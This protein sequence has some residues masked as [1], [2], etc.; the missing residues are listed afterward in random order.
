HV[1]PVGACSNPDLNHGLRPFG[2]LRAGCGLYFF[3][4]LRL[5]LYK[6]VYPNSP[7]TSAATRNIA[8]TALA[9]AG[10][11]PSCPNL[12]F[13]RQ[14]GS[15]RLLVG[16][17]VA[18]HRDGMCFRRGLIA[19]IKNLVARAQIFLGVP[20]TVQAPLHLQRFLLV[21]EWHLID[22]TVA[23]VASHTL[24]DVNAVIEKYE[25]GKLVDAGPLQGFAAAK[26]GA[27]RLQ[28]LGVGPDLR[29]TVHAGLGGRNAGKT[30]SLDRG[31]AIAAVDAKAR[32]MVLMT[33]WYR[34]RFS[35]TG[36][37]DV[38]RALDLHCNPGQCS[39]HK[40]RAVNCDARQGICTALKNLRHSS[41]V[42]VTFQEA[43]NGALW[44]FHGFLK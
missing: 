28:Q 35:Y 8:Y 14:E 32:D 27:H 25:V 39:Y 23:G 42:L 5:T 30:R 24:V 10:H 13:R 40:H 4:P 12:V 38:R 16:E 33:K 34:L 3:A 29:M 2:R 18:I 26:A 7:V 11:Q 1:R 37:G 36:V 41:D 31:V 17:A 44:I 9:I 6:L 15:Q 43:L 19:H 20:M 22:R 21:H